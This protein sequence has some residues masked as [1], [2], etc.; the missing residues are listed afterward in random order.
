LLVDAIKGHPL[1]N[2]NPEGEGVVPNTMLPEVARHLAEKYDAMYRPDANGDPYWWRWRARMTDDMGIEREVGWLGHTNLGMGGFNGGAGPAR[3]VLGTHPEFARVGYGYFGDK[4]FRGFVTK[5][6]DL[7]AVWHDFA[8]PDIMVAPK[9]FG[10]ECLGHG[11][12]ALVHAGD[13]TGF[14][15]VND[16]GVPVRDWTDIVDYVKTGNDFPS[17]GWF[18]PGQIAEIE[19]CFGGLIVQ[20]VGVPPAV[21]LTA[22]G[23]AATPTV[24]RN[25]LPYKWQLYWYLDGTLIGKAASLSSVTFPRSGRARC[26]LRAYVGIHGYTDGVVLGSAEVDVV[27]AVPVPEPTPEPTKPP[28]KRRKRRKW[29]FY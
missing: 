21:T 14:N 3:D 18:V 5:I 27:V 28:R 19:G 23:G 20:N 17:L 4:E 8:A 29:W 22:N 6:P 11:L 9:S 7:G 12:G 25:P 15:F 2:F 13:V 16:R 26:E 1:F 24:Q 10:H